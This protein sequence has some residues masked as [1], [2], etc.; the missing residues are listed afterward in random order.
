MDFNDPDLSLM[1]E[2]ARPNTASVQGQPLI[3]GTAGELLTGED[4]R[5][6]WSNT[7][8]SG[9]PTWD[10][11]NSNHNSGAAVDIEVN[12]FPDFNYQPRPYWIHTGREGTQAFE[13]AL[14]EAVK[15]YD[16]QF[17]PEK[18]EKP[19]TKEDIGFLGLVT[20]IKREN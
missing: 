16:V 10:T 2:A 19:L 14:K 3:V 4:G 9:T 8:S 7:T 11:I 12:Q 1:W 5:I 15:Y 18:E 17:T 13:E 20:I 6:F